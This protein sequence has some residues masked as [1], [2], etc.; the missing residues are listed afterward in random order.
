VLS[1]SLQRPLALPGAA[2]AGRAAAGAPNGRGGGAAAALPARG[3]RV[4]VVA[5]P[6]RGAEGAVRYRGPCHWQTG[7]WLGGPHRC[8]V[9][10]VRVA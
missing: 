1:S 9:A 4:R 2:S 8:V 7:E 5:G 10:C 3:A 6:Q